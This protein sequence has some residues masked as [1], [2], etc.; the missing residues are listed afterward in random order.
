[1]GVVSRVLPAEPVTSLA[2]YLALGSGRGLETAHKLGAPA[3]IGE[4][5]ASGLR[6]RGGAGFP[7]GDKWR[8]VADFASAGDI[9]GPHADATKPYAIGEGALIATLAVGT[10]RVVIVI[11]PSFAAAA[12]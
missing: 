2:A 12:T 3:V 8:T 9:Q 10:D 11:K 4:V 5:E 1:M 6:G 7:T